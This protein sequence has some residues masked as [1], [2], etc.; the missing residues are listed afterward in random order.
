MASTHAMR[1]I[2]S[3]PMEVYD[4]IAIFLANDYVSLLDRRDRLKCLRLVNIPFNRSATRIL[5]SWVHIQMRHLGED[6]DTLERR[7]PSRR[8]SI[9][10]GDLP[11]YI[12]V[13][14]ITIDWKDPPHGETWWDEKIQERT[15]ETLSFC[16]GRLPSLQRL[17]IDT[18]GYVCLYELVNSTLKAL[19][20]AHLPRLSSLKIGPIGTPPV[21][22]D[23][24]NPFLP[25]LR[26]LVISYGNPRKNED[27]NSNVLR[28]LQLG[29]ELHSI[30]LFSWERAA[31]YGCPMYE[32]MQPFFHP[33]ANIERLH[34]GWITI[35]Y[36]FLGTICNYRKSLADLEFYSVC[37]SSGT[38]EDFFRE[39]GECPMLSVLRVTSTCGYSYTSEGLSD[40]DTAAINLAKTKAKEREESLHWKTGGWSKKT[41]SLGFHLDALEVY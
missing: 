14:R 19:Q 16:L 31:D 11:R 37:L 10:E 13:L 30:A 28:L 5:F 9:F 21:I 17:D 7:C 27:L 38:W 24:L 39:L 35:P 22:D 25:Q 1:G 8:K 4:E 26:H 33:C 41:A 2:A 36:E 3:L 32:S 23:A 12:R 6:K 20:H 29:H 15:Y 18:C 34:L 40:S